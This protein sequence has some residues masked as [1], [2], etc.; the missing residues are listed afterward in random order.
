MNFKVFFVGLLVVLTV[1][2]FSLGGT[3][4][5]LYNQENTLKQQ[6]T[7]KQRNNQSEFDNMWKKIKQVSN[8]NDKY[9]EGFVEALTAYTQ[10]RSSSKGSVKGGNTQLGLNFV[11]EA[12][13]NLSQEGY[14]QVTNIITSSRDRFTAQQTQLLDMEREHNTLVTQMPNA[15]FFKAMHIG[16]IHVTI[17]T[18]TRSEKSFATGKDDDVEL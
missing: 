9:K 16:E 4:M 15:L 14:K 17:V 13:P 18:S 10:G 12:I 2:G 1:I 7:A 5:D 6:I 3:A 8:V 11:H